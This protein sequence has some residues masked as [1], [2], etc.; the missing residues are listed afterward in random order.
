MG[1]SVV[2]HRGVGAGAGGQHQGRSGH[3]GHCEG[4]LR[5]SWQGSSF[6]RAWRCHPGKVQRN[7]ARAS[8][9]RGGES[10]HGGRW[11]HLFLRLDL[12]RD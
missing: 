8:E 5:E 3:Q 11:E 4:A 10:L 7:G 9:G 1:Q 6:S 2:H 12:G